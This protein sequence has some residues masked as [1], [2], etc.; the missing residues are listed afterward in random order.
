MSFG[1]FRHRASGLRRNAPSPEQGASRRTRS[2]D[3]AIRCK[4]GLPALAPAEKPSEPTA[5]AVPNSP[6]GT[7]TVVKGDSLWRIA[8]KQ[9][10]DGNRWNEIFEGNKGIIQKPNLI[11]VG[12]QIQLPAA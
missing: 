10:G 11:Y 5:P 6:A 9:L 2:N 1:C 8:Q 12:Q 7:Y 3:P 4:L